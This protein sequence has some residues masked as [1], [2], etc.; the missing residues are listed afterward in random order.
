MADYVICKIADNGAVF[1]GQM[2]DINVMKWTTSSSRGK[3]FFEL[4]G[5]KHRNFKMKEF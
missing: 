1:V 3:E 2:D 5:I 4:H